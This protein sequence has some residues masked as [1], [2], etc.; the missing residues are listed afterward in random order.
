VAYGEAQKFARSFAPIAPPWLSRGRLTEHCKS[1]LDNGEFVFAL[2]NHFARIVVASEHRQAGYQTVSVCP[3]VV[4]R[5]AIAVAHV[6]VDDASHCRLRKPILDRRLPKMK[7]AGKS[8]SS[9]PQ[10]PELLS[11]D[12]LREG[13]AG[14]E[15]RTND[16]PSRN[17]R[18]GQLCRQQRPDI[19]KRRQG[20]DVR[21]GR[22]ERAQALRRVGRNSIRLIGI[23]DIE[24][25]YT[26]R[27]AS[28]GI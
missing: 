1:C 6:N 7:K 16:K 4:E 17:S 19:R 14:P 13:G 5:S 24:R 15:R 23:H 26:A 18:V 11:S 22:A 12:T 3:E 21:D 2:S 25:M 20:R 9:P 28:C 10:T 8:G 27:K